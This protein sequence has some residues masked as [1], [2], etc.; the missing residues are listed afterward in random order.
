MADGGKQGT[1][2]GEMWGWRVGDRGGRCNARILSADITNSDRFR[3]YLAPP[4]A[5]RPLLG[6]WAE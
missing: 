1:W 5:H 6:G 4:A 2:W 3:P